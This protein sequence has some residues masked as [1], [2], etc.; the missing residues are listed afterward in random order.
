MS[1]ILIL[2]ALGE[3][4]DENQHLR[5]HRVCVC[6]INRKLFHDRRQF[7][8]LVL[9]SCTEFYSLAPPIVLM[10]MSMNIHTEDIYNT[11][12]SHS[13]TFLRTVRRTTEWLVALPY[14][15]QDLRFCEIN[16]FSR[17]F[18]IPCP[19]NSMV[20]YPVAGY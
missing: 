15:L 18:Y 4:R 3:C 10:I 17:P 14:T 6:A 8:K 16:A 7:S 19:S 13:H 11:R 12:A 1:V 20:P 5:N 2:S 9:P